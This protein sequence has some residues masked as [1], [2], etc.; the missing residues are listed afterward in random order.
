MKQVRR[1]RRK[2]RDIVY[3]NTDRAILA[4]SQAVEVFTHFTG[5]KPVKG[6]ILR[7]GNIVRIPEG[8]PFEPTH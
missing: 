6:L 2:S 7:L 4:E 5:H 1:N 8:F 3:T